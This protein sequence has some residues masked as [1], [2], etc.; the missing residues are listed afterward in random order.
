MSTE[1]ESDFV[2]T[3]APLR[4]DVHT[5][6][7]LV[8]EVLVEQS[9]HAL[10]EAVE[11]VRKAAIERR[12]ARAGL[13]ALSS[14]VSGLELRAGEQLVRAFST[15]FQVVNL[16][17]R[18][19]RIR[20]RREYQRTTSSPQPGGLCATLLELRGLGVRLA[21]IETLLPRLNFEPVFTAHPTEAVRR[22]LLEKENEI[23]RALIDDLDRNQ[24]AR[25]RERGRERMRM[26]I[27]S[28]WQTSEQSAVR[29]SVADEVDHTA[30][31]LV[32]VLYRALPVFYEDF[33]QALVDVYG[34]APDLPA[35]VRFGSWVGGDMDGNP[36]VGALTIRDT[37]ASHTELLLQRYAA[38][39]A[40]LAR[41]LSQSVDRVS[42]AEGVLERLAHYRQRLPEAAARLR[43][44]HQDMPYRLLLLL[45]AARIRAT[46]HGAAPAAYA[47][48]G[49]LL[50]D[51]RLIANSLRLHRGQSAGWFPLRRFMRRVASFGFHLAS[52]DVRQD[53]RVHAR[54]V[55]ELALE[56]AWP[57]LPEGER[58]AGLARIGRPGEAVMAGLTRETRDTLAVFGAIGAARRRHGSEAIGIYIISMTRAA[59]DVGAVL[60][61][62]RA[63]GLIEGDGAVP[64][65]VAPLFETIDDLRA[66]PAVLEALLAD[67]DYRA[68]LA[69]R[70]RQFVMLGYSDSCKDGGLLASRWGLQRAQVELTEVARRNAVQLV[71]FHG[72][73]G[74]A[75]RGGG[76]TERAVIA[77]PRGSVDGH[78]RL[79]EQ[80]EVIH[81]NYGMRAIALR[82]LEQASAAA[83]RATLRPRPPE[84]REDRWREAMHA[85]ADAG[86]QAYRELIYRSAGFVEYFRA[87]TPIDV[88][89]RMRIGSRPPKRQAGSGGVDSLRAIPWVFAWSQTRCG[90]SAWY[91]VGSGLGHGVEQYGLEFVQEM[92]ADWPFFRTLIDDIEMVLAKS[93]LAIAE[94][95]SQLAGAELHA[96]FFPRI[97]AE[98]ERTEREV[99]ALKR[100]GRLL[101]GDRRLRLSIRLRNPYVDPISLIQAD[102]LR[103]WREEGSP[104]NETFRALV[105]TVNGI[106]AGVQNTG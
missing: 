64:L 32:D 100:A 54:A 3:D 75:S 65:D 13:D 30:F 14:S 102:L 79:T 47:D 55:A 92:A 89:E 7:D 85:I 96:Q 21:D 78:L 19:H 40:H 73:G 81:R 36:N 49:E 71:Y 106:A 68:H 46:T 105:G 12:E 91:G 72:R 33:E 37:V 60:A 82:N 58:A 1:R 93:D 44:R 59:S 35:V 16:A 24:T 88:I 70:G 18:V 25:E 97:A 9:G 15:Y 63:G 80:G 101:D 98:F 77:M 76:K 48:A 11:R 90:L 99:L 22:T 6:G 57:Q 31:Y 34:S 53:S 8:G 27:A 17:E 62:A 104:E 87:A 43:P 103:R 51:L 66:A 94:R 38:E 83:I 69:R 50:D 42:V 23:A 26:A 10:L 56:P 41:L 74:S 29:P 84:P 2:A 28:A 67:P 5:L 39:A 45:I 86:E 4:D 95:Y 52:L 20:R 61:L